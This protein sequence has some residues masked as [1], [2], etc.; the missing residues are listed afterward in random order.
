M[1]GCLSGYIALEMTHRS[2]TP[3][4]PPTSVPSARASRERG[5]IVLVSALIVLGMGVTGFMVAKLLQSRLSMDADLR[6][7]NYGGTLAQYTAESGINALLYYWNTSQVT[8]PA[9]P[10]AYP[11]F[12]PIVATYSIAGGATF[13]ATTTCTYS[14]TIS[15]AHP[16]YTVIADATA[17]S[18]AA[19]SDWRNITRRVTVTVASDSQYTITGYSR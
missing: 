2:D 14:I 8:P 7:S 10:A 13:T 1:K 17:S 6:L 4:A 9:R 15:G 19:G 3:P 5:N 18:A 16:T 11:T 12:N